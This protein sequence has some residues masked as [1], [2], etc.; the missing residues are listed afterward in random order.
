M[1]ETMCEIVSISTYKVIESTQ[2]QVF[3]DRIPTET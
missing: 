1:G 3:M 2:K